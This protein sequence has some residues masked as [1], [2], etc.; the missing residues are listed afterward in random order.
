MWGNGTARVKAIKKVGDPGSYLTAYLGDIEFSRK[1]LVILRDKGVLI[2]SLE[3]R[4]VEINGK[5]KSFIK[6]G[7]LHF[8]PTGMKIFR[9]S[10]GIKEPVIFYDFCSNREKV[11]GNCEPKYR[12][13]IKVFDD[14][15]RQIN[16]IAYEQYN[17]K[18]FHH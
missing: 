1:N 17:K 14:L 13:N 9:K 18:D 4:D 11:I 15:Q 3:Y 8:Y 16:Y 5:K 12:E 6:G 10:K 2:G 7:R